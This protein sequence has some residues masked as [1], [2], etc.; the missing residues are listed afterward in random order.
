VRKS[1]SAQN[2]TKH[3]FI[4]GQIPY[5]SEL[6]MS[7]S[8]LKRH[9][10]RHKT[11]TCDKC[12]FVTDL[13]SV[14]IKHKKTHSVKKVREC[15]KPQQCP[16]CDKILSTASSLRVHIKTMHAKRFGKYLT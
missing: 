10:A 1:I 6:K 7:F 15:E 14:M 8:Q 16:H 4:Q 9:M 5:F 12:D 11:H 3:L 2:A 13:M